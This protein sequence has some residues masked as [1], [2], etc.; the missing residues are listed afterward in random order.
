[1]RFIRGLSVYQLN[2]TNIFR[3]IETDSALHYDF[4]SILLL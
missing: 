3:F 2:E 4:K 1:M